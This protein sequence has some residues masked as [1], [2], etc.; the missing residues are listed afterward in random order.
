MLAGYTTVITG[1]GSGMG[2]AAAQRF[3][4][5]EARVVVSD[6]D[7]AAAVAVAREIDPSGAR[8]IGVRC[9]V[10]R[11]ADCAH[12]VAEAEA[13]FGTP[14]DVFMANAGVSF[15]GDFLDASPETLQRI[16]DVNVTG[17]IFSA[18]AAL[19]SLVRS[20]RAS[21]VFTSSISGVTGRAKRSVYNASKHALGGLV[22]ALALEFGPAGVRVNAIAPGAT[23]TP[24][25]RAHLAKVNP[26]IDKA[27]AGI[28]GVMPLGH[29]ISPEDFADAA[30]FLVSSASRSITGHTLVLDG[31]ATA[32]RM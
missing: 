4:R 11:A 23:D 2:A 20:P 9:D 24:F 5:E 25:L 21:L 14:I 8:A 32:G 19:R 18:Q 6:I 10:A 22:K 15:A 30:V 13:F 12:L 26:D 16:V 1:A 7:E 17:S 28:V 27:V 31:G 3:A 29:L